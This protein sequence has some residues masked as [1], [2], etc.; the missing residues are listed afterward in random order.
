[1]F[2]VPLPIAQKVFEAIL[3]KD[4]QNLLPH[5]TMD[6]VQKLMGMMQ[7]PSMDLEELVEELKLKE[8]QITVKGLIV[9]YNTP[10]A[11]LITAWIPDG[12]TYKLKDFT[13][14]AN[15]L[16]ILLNYSKVKRIKDK[17]DAAK[18]EQTVA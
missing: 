9:E 16:W 18:M 5:M 13:Y 8:T 12:D 7:G 11:K 14:K 2:A 10:P 3:V 6:I 1:M 17:M 4:F 15:W